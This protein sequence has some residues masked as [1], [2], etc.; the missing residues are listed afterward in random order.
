MGRQ[1]FNYVELFWSNSIAK[2]FSYG[3]SELMKSDKQYLSW[4]LL[5]SHVD[6]LVNKIRKDQIRAI[7]ELGEGFAKFESE[8][9]FDRVVGIERGGCIPGVMMSHR[10][11]LPFTALKWSTRDWI[12][13]DNVIKML[14]WNKKHILLVDDISDSGDTIAGILKRFEAIASE[15]KVTTCALLSKVTS[16]NKIDYYARELTTPEELDSWYVFPWEENN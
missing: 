12:E 8:V 13:K 4:A 2:E 6:V 3:I 1:S 15:A 11:N 14:Q 9:I 5:D 7:T 16:I 10:M